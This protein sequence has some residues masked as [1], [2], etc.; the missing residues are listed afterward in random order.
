M[1]YSISLV[2]GLI[3]LSISIFTLKESFLFVKGSSRAIGTVIKLEEVNSDVP[4]E[5][6]TYKPIFK[7]TTIDNQ[8]II[9]RDAYSNSP[10][11][12]Y[13]GETIVLAYDTKNPYS[14]KILTYFETFAWTIIL[15]TISMPLIIIG[16][17][18]HL[19]SN[20]F[21]QIP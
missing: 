11:V 16:G 2:V 1:I 10:P 13:V 18:Y 20:L 12:W 5:G 15:M 3:T 9:Y 14:V 4:G 6:I 19:A 17:G 8:E 7:F 21:K